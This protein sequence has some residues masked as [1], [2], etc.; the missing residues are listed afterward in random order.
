[1]PGPTRACCTG[2]MPHADPS[3]PPTAGAL[4]RRIVVTGTTG[5]GKTT[6]ARAAAARLGVPHTEQDAWNHMP[7]WREARSRSSGRRWTA[8]R[9]RPRG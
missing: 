4:P 8:S 5:S 3:I 1:M 9:P 7:G 6:L 2:R